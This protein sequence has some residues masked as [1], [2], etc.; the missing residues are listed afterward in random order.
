MIQIS[1]FNL[2]AVFLTSGYTAVTPNEDRTVFE[3]EGWAGN[4]MNRN[5]P[6][7]NE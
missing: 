5:V 3:V 6:F 1:Y 4:E 7:K 2:E